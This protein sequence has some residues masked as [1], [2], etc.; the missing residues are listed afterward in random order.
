MCVSWNEIVETLCNVFF[1][2][3]LFKS[4]ENPTEEKINI[5]TFLSEV[6]LNLTH[7]SA[8]IKQNKN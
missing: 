4:T 8:E 7:F 5:D 3:F 1:L 6:C 2:I